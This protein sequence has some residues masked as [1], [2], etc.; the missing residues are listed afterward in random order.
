MRC[1]LD[2]L[3]YNLLIQR[4]TFLS[5]SAFSYIHMNHFFPKFVWLTLIRISDLFSEVFVCRNQVICSLVLRNPKLSHVILHLF[6]K[7]VSMFRTLKGRYAFS[8]IVSACLYLC[9]S[10]INW[11]ICK[12]CLNTIPL[13][14]TQVR[15]S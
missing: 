4:N 9:E 14:S 10:R 12:L 8:I 2:I 11:K 1:Y 5:F 15:N 6:C 13:K 7:F 3:Y